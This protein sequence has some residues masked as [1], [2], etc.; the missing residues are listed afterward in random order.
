LFTVINTTGYYFANMAVNP[1]PLW[2]V[3]AAIVASIVERYEIGPI[4]DNVLI[5][6]TTMIILIVG[7]M[8]A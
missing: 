5:T 1:I 3:L 6:V 4:D 7:T 2:G 8:I